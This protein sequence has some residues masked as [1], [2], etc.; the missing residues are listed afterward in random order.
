M[1][2]PLATLSADDRALLRRRL[3]TPVL[4]FLALLA[5]RS[6]GWIPQAALAP[7]RLLRGA[8]PSGVSWMRCRL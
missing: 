5:L 8:A 7:A 2:N 1:R 3:R 4:T 6:A